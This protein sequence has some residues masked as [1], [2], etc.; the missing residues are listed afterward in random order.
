MLGPLLFLLFINDIPDITTNTTTLFADDS[1]L[2]GNA[3]SPDIIQSDLDC[4]SRWADVW[5]MKLNESKCSV[6]HVG[7]DNPRRNYMMGNTPLQVVEKQRDL[8]VVISAG[9]NIC[10]EEQKK[11]NDW[12]SKTNDVMDH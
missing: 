4:L 12:K 3:N 9:D 2:I 1:K 11:G 10:W 6:L 5:Q 8:G 7:K